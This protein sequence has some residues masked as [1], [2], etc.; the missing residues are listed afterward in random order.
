MEYVS[1]SLLETQTFD[2]PG[3]PK[4]CIGDLVPDH[5][6]YAI[7]GGIPHSQTH[8]HPV[9]CMGSN[10]LCRIVPDQPGGTMTTELLE[11]DWIQLLTS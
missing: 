4:I 1:Q 7:H 6:Y 2:L 10:R 5:H 11:S 3:A 9:R 8:Q